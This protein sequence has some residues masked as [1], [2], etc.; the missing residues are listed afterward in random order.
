MIV[1]G[2]QVRIWKEVVVAYFYMLSRHLSQETEKNCEN[3]LDSRQLGRGANQVPPKSKSGVLL[4]QRHVSKLC[5]NW[6][7]FYF[8]S[9]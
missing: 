2:L 7:G 5:S 1:N 6:G 8:P 9:W 3:N 4:L